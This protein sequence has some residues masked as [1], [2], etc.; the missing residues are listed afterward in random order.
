MLQHKVGGFTQNKLIFSH[1]SE[2]QKSEVSL[3]G[4]NS[5][6][7]GTA[8]SSSRL[9]EPTPCLLPISWLG[10]PTPPILPPWAHHLLLL[11][12]QMSLCLPLIGTPVITFWVH[13]DNP[14]SSPHLKILH[15]IG[16][17]P[18]D[19]V[20]WHS[21]APGT[22][23]WACFRG[24]SPSPHKSSNDGVSCGPCAHFSV[25]SEGG[26]GRLGAEE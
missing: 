6:G 26:H 25:F 5:K 18:S 23:T 21:P 8:A 11:W 22:R 19:H 1:F 14:G 24:P 3:T 20:R 16:T 4:L 15:P 13:L 17:R 12:G 9:R 7:L 2:G 10:G